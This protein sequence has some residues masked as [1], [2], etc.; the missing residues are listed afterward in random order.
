VYH[1]DGYFPLGEKVCIVWATMD[2]LMCT[3]SIWHMATISVDRY[4]SIRFPLRYQRTK[5]TVFVVAKIA[6]VWIVSIGICSFL[7]FAGLFNPSVV[8]RD[9]LCVPAVPEFVI[10]GSIF[11]FFVPLLLMFATYALTVRTLARN[12]RTIASAWKR[13]ILRPFRVR[14]ITFSSSSS[15]LSE[16]GSQTFLPIPGLHITNVESTKSQLSTAGLEPVSL[17]GENVEQRFAG[18]RVIRVDGRKAVYGTP[19]MP[20]L[21]MIQQIVGSPQP[22]AER[23]RYAASQPVLICAPT[24][25]D[26]DD[27]D[28]VAYDDDNEDYEAMQRQLTD[29]TVTTTVVAG[30]NNQNNDDSNDDDNDDKDCMLMRLRQNDTCRRNHVADADVRSVMVDMDRPDTNTQNLIDDTRKT[31]HADVETRRHNDVSPQIV[32]Q[33]FDDVSRSSKTVS[34]RTAP[35]ETITY[36]YSFAGGHSAATVAVSQGQTK[37]GNVRRKATRVLGVMFVVFVI[38]WTPFFV[39]NILS[40]VCP[41]CTQS[42]TSTVWTVLVWLGWVSSLANPIIYTSFSPAFRAAFRRL[43]TCRRGGASL[44]KAKYRQQLWTSQLRR[45]R[46][47]TSGNQGRRRSSSTTPRAS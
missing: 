39:L 19:S 11:A 43:L 30:Q 1:V 31:S 37:S 28:D 23:I 17:L 14:T 21:M 6:F 35:V 40:A 22:I 32:E 33:S 20:D 3:A 41:H 12:M 18:G 25:A 13:Q 27:D 26:N 38:L 8:Y 46:A 16:Q 15:E 34:H 4:C 5:S 29:T 47:Q 36:G 45:R 10:Y 24:T 7:A 2:V 42:V 9:G 44:A